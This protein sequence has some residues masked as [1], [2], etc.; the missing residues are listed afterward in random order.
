M[1][2]IRFLSFPP[3]KKQRQSFATR[4]VHPFGPLM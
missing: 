2:R 3:M 4:L 1:A